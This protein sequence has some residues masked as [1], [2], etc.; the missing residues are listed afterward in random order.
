M[1]MLQGLGDFTIG[2]I[3]PFLFILT[4]VVFVHE[5]GHF[6]VARWNGVTV[7]VFSVGFG[8][9]LVGFTDSKGTRWR[10]SIIPLGGY[11][12]FLG[13]ENAA[14]SAGREALS[15]LNENEQRTAFA[16][17]SVGARAAIVAAGPIA[18]F[19]LGV[20]IFAFI[21][22]V[23]GRT[24]IPADVD[25]I[26]PDSPAQEAGFEI[27]DRVIAVDGAEIN[28][29]EDLRRIVSL[30]AGEEL[31]VVV[32]RDGTPVEL[33]V[34]PAAEEADDGLGGTYRRGLIGIQQNLDE[35]EETLEILPV[36]QALWRGVEE[37]TFIITQTVSYFGRL[38]VGQESIDQLGGPI[39]VARYA[40]Q[41]ASVSFWT[42]VA[43]AGY[44]SV[45][46]GFINLLPIPL[47]DGGHLLFFGIE[48]LRRKPLGDRAQEIGLRIGLTLVLMLMVV[49]LTNDLV[50]LF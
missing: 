23:I 9:E 27:G 33:T 41:A 16:T 10:L 17:Q 25:G 28:S 49:A 21:A 5:L 24:V 48:A 22:A 6:A 39:T 40:E 37:T 34:T 47:L 30:S 45:S 44:L 2:L 13:D 26:V 14:S 32:D 12:R 29:F 31:L 15:N 35:G 38:I 19:V 43:L 20:L 1:E 4:L 7:K 8:R 50:R 18:N 11:V 46:I 36:P 42:L 3:I